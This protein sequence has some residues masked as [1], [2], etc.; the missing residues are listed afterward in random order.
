VL[1]EVGEP[2]LLVIGEPA[3]SGAEL[4]LLL[5][6]GIDLVMQLTIG[7]HAFILYPHLRLR[8]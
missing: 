4:V 7:R 8:M 5:D 1:L 3:P 2:L 6:E